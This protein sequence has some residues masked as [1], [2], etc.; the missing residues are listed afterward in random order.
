MSEEKKSNTACHTPKFRVSYPKVFKPEI[1][2]LSKQPEYSLV[3]L[4]PK[5]ADLSKL[6][7]AA[8]EAIIKK[9]GADPNKWPDNLRTP[10]RDQKE[11]AKK[12]DDGRRVLPDGY[13]EGAIYINLKSKQKPGVVDQNVQPIL[14]ETEFYAGCYAVASLNAYAYDQAGNRGVAF[15]LNN[16]QKVADGDPFSGRPKPEDDFAPIAGAETA[17]GGTEASSTVDPFSL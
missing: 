12:L 2:K 5:G 17:V 16:I 6:K 4:F 1:N 9:W 15:G 11:R 8:K 3:A 13:E 10:F 7:A 14:D